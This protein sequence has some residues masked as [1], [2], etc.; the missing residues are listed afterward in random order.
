MAKGS[1]KLVE[2]YDKI[3]E[4]LESGKTKPA[5]RLLETIRAKASKAASK[6]KKASKPNAYRTFMS[7]TIKKLRVETPTLDAP[8]AMKK[9]AVVWRGLSDAEKKAFEGRRPSRPSSKKSSK[10][11]KKGGAGTSRKSSKKASR[12]GKK[13][14]KKA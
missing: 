14:S 9:A 3:K 13:A 11:S 8:N 12:K 1:V 7:I 5:L 6:S 2:K 4:Y 10:S